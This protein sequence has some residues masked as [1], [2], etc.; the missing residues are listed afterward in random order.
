MK[1]K[2]LIL[3]FIAIIITS[4]G[5]ENNENNIIIDADTSSCCVDSVCIDSVNVSIL[6]TIT[7]K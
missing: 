5:V 1:I 4:C 6:D 7:A 3:A 2:F